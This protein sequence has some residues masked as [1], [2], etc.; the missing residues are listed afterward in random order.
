MYEVKPEDSPDY[1]VWRIQRANQSPGPSGAAGVS[2]ISAVVSP[3][4]PGYRPR[5]VPPPHAL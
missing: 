3:A 5:D 1:F 2:L 4:D